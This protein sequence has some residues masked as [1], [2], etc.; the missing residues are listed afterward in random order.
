MNE[1]MWIRRTKAAIDRDEGSYEVAFDKKT[2]M[3]NKEKTSYGY[4]TINVTT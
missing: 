1:A 2:N 4:V 3:S